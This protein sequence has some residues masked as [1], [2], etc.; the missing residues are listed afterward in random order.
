MERKPRAEGGPYIGR[1]M[2]R[3]EDLRLVRGAGKYSDDI[4]MTGQAYAAFVRT[5]HAHAVVKRVDVAA[6]QKMPGV[7]AVLTGADY[8]ADGLKGALQR[9][10]PA[11]AIDIKVRAFDPAKRPVLEEEQY[12]LVADRV[13]YPGEAVA[14]VIAETRLA[15]R[16]A[17]EAV[18]VEYEVLPAATDVRKAQR[19]E[20]IWPDACPDNVALDET[21]GDVDAVRAAFD[22]ADL[23]VEQ[24][25][26]NQRIANCQMEP[27]S[28]VGSYDA[29]TDSYTLISGNQGVHAPRMVLAESW[30]LPLDK[31]RFICPDVGGGFG[32]RNNLYPEQTSILWAAKRVGRPVKWTNDRS[33]SF[34]TDY[35]GRDLVTTASLAFTKDG[36]ITAYRVDH[37]GTCGGQT[38]TYVP[39]SN[40][41]RVATT[42][43]DIPLMHMRCR[44]MMTNT[45]PTAPFRGAGRPEATLV[46]ER[47]IDMAAERLGMDRL[48]IRQVN[49]IPKKKLPYRTASGLLYD[50]GDFAN[51]MK[52]MIEVSDWK[53]FTA[54]KRESKK[55]GKLRGIGISNYLETPVGI[56]H[57]RV[58]VTV[59]PTGKVQ[60]AVGTQST[61]QGHET[62]FAQVMADLLGVRPEDILFVCGDTSK[63]PSGSGTHSDRS[64]RLGGTLMFQASEDVV[65]QAKAASAAILGVPES[66]VSFSDGLFA[67]PNSNRRLTIFDVAQAVSENSSLNGGKPLESKKTFTGRIPAYPTGCAICEVE[68]DPDTGAVNIPRYGSIDDAGQAINPLILHGQVHGGI[69]QGVGQALVEN[70]QYDEQGQV[71]TGSFMD[72]G[73]PRAHMVPSFDIALT[74]DPTKGNPLRVKGGGEAGITPALA[75]VM[76]AIMDALKELGVEHIDMP[77]TPA[78][79]WGAIQEGRAARRPA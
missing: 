25:F 20:P 15:A 4:S 30:G 61:G 12:P 62:S 67:A 17:A 16:D 13:R 8:I 19:S 1:P 77:A 31:I 55:R 37:I 52:R 56:P 26:V 65:A 6:A 29:V 10:N 51:N 32:L 74:E 47:L 44:S 14:M 69:V 64:M 40:A 21:F 3:F 39:L 78:R 59:L 27:R 50:S 33:E 38:V 49:V 28:G 71:L 57:E 43:Y 9:A 24:T 73:V 45:V 35:A 76:N 68:I 7:I 11:G 53:G 36:R 79:I 72:Y 75:V 23:V 70:V 54:R 58:E 60:L 42:V 5:P 41:Y 63:I 18:Q 22:A 66:D 2:P 46:L 48:R 34:L